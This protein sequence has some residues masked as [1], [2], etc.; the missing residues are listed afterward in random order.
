MRVRI[1]VGVK[2]RIIGLVKVWNRVR[3]KVMVWVRVQ[4]RVEVW[5][6]GLGAILD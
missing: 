2:V 4:V 3:V 6:R 1:R 5:V